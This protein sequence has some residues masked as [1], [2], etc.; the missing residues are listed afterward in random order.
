VFPPA[1]SGVFGATG[2]SVAEELG[3]ALLGNI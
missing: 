3:A 1:G 2:R